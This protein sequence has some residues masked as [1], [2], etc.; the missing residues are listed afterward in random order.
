LL[1]AEESS[2]SETAAVEDD[3]LRQAQNFLLAGEL[4]GQ[5]TSERPDLRMV[6]DRRQRSWLPLEMFA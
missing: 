1:V 3:P 6:V 5:G 4:E 2:R